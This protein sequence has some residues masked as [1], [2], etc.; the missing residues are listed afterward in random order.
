MESSDRGDLSK[1]HDVL[2][3]IA[4][5]F[6]DVCHRLGL[7]YYLAEGSLL[8]AVRHGGIIPWDDDMDFVMP[9]PDYDRFLR[10]APALL[11]EDF[12]LTTYENGNG[13]LRWFFK[14]ED[15][16][17]SVLCEAQKEQSVLPAW[18]DVFPLDGLPD[19]SVL[20]KW[21]NFRILVRRALMQFS[22]FEKTVN[23]KKQNRPLHERIL[24]GVGKR[25]SLEKVLD[26]RSLMRGLDRMLRKYP[27]DRK[28]YCINAASA[29]KSRATMPR[30]WY[31]QGREYP[32]GPL[33]LTGPDHPECI[34][35][36]LYGDYQTLP[37]EEQRNIH[38]TRLLD[39]GEN[40]GKDGEL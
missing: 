14:L 40:D 18:V 2:M 17:T 35:R 21:A 8:G 1:L 27:F 6:A 33:R 37:P 22:Q 24:I 9:R 39:M 3:N 20:R 4:A 34:L 13:G 38:H 36:Q 28:K 32:F 31:G 12:R 7:R 26:T 5:A 29:Y 16:R 15:L 25:I 19:S 30:E 11:P 23:V 10:E